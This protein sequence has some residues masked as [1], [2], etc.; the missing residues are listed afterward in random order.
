MSIFKILATKLW[1]WVMCPIWSFFINMS[2]W[3][4]R[5]FKISDAL[6]K[7]KELLNCSSIN[8]VLSKFKWKADNYKDWYPWVITIVNKDL[9]DDCDG[10]AILAK[11][12]WKNKNVGSRIVFIY[13]ADGTQGHAVCVTYNNTIFVSNSEVIEIDPINW[14]QDL[15]SRFD[16]IYVTIIEN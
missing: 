3:I 9:E 5:G 10:A 14:Q 15:L 1:I 12:W 4:N 13:S 11:W 8:E 2:Y 7:K 16:N 6:A